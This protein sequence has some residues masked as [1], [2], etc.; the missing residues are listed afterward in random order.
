MDGDEASDAAGENERGENEGAAEGAG[1]AEAPVAAEGY[2]D[3]SLK[4][5]GLPAGETAADFR[6]HGHF[7]QA[8]AGSAQKTARRKKRG[9]HENRHNNLAAIRR[10]LQRSGS[11]GGVFFYYLT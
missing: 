7:E 9:E 11:T 2:D 8:A 1:G 5:R 6:Y 3:I 10:V 4:G